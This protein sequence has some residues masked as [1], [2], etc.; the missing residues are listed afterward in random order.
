MKRPIRSELGDNLA[1]HLSEKHMHLHRGALWVSFKG[2]PYLCMFGNDNYENPKTKAYVERLLGCGWIEK[3]QSEG[4]AAHIKALFGLSKSPKPS[5]VIA[6][7]VERPGTK[8]SKKG[9]EALGQT[10]SALVWQTWGF[11]FENKSN[12]LATVEGVK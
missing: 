8:F 12:E 11:G 4:R 9:R 10:L 1:E 5:W 6:C 2:T 7:N 3:A